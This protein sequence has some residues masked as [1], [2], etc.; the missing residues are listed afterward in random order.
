MPCASERYVSL[1][2][3]LVIPLE[4]LLLALDLEGRGFQ[5]MPDGGDLVVRPAA[6]L[7]SE[8]VRLLKRWKAHVIELLSYR[9]SERLQ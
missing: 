9:V 6:N 2:G 8:D 1:R 3:G 5:M 4:P 7:T